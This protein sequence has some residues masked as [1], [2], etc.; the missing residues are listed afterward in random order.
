[1]ERFY[2]ELNVLKANM[3][4]NNTLLSDKR[5]D[6]LIEEILTLRCQKTKKNPRDFWLKKSLK[7]LW[8]E[9]KI[10]HGKPRHSQSQ[11]S[12]E[13]ANQDIENMLTIWMQEQNTSQWSQGLRFIQL[14][15][16]RAYHSGIKTTP[17]EALFGCKIKIGLNTSNLPKEIVEN[18]DTEEH[19]TAITESKSSETITNAT[20]VNPIELEDASTTITKIKTN[21]ENAINLRKNATKKLENQADKMK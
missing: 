6:E 15:K 19:L 11:G 20:T 7:D 3:G 10:I 12:V 8:P 9:L 13:R 5:Y 17:Y 21:N 18:I 16:N 4:K 1:M 14:M 2:E